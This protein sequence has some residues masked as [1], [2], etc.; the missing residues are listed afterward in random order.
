[1]ELR[2]TVESGICGDG[3]NVHVT[4]GGKTGLSG[5]VPLRI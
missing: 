4:D 1:M 2:I 3:F 5:E